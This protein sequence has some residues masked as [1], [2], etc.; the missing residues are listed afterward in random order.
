VAF[1]DPDSSK[2]KVLLAERYLYVFGNRASVLKWKQHQKNSKGKSKST[3]G[4]HPDASDG[5]D[6]KDI[7]QLLKTQAETQKHADTQT[8]TTQSL[9]QQPGTAKIPPRTSSRSHGKK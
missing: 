3:A 8:S 7:E 6:D 9:Q 5:N 2:L 1:E 4:K